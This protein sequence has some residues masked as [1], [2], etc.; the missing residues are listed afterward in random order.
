MQLGLQ[1]QHGGWGQ[2]LTQDRRG[3]PRT[4]SCAAWGW[5]RPSRGEDPASRLPTNQTRHQR[6]RDR[7]CGA[8]MGGSQ[9]LFCQNVF[10]GVF[11]PVQT[12][13]PAPWQRRGGVSGT[14]GPLETGCAYVQRPYSSAERAR[15]AAGFLAASLGRSG[16]RQVNSHCHPGVFLIIFLGLLQT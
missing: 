2:I 15:G 4:P 13:P 8:H 6:A 5:H 16:L 12:Y 1:E 14:C 11:L 3:H 10:P 7:Q 9:S